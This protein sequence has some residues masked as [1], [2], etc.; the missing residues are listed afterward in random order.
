MAAERVEPTVVLVPLL[1]PEYEV[2]ALEVAVF[3]VLTFS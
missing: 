3:T 1:P 2:D